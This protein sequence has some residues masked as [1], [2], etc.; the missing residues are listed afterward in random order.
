MAN[1]TSMSKSDLQCH[2]C[3]KILKEPVN[4]PCHCTICHG[5]LTDGSVK[6]GI[7]KCESCNEMFAVKDIELVVNKYAKLILDAEVHLSPE[8]K[9]MKREIEKLCNEFQLLYD[10]LQH[11]QAAF[12]VSSYNHFAEIKHQI[13][14]QREELKD[15]IDK[16]SLAMI[17]RVEQYEA[18]YKLKL[19]ENRCFKEFNGETNYFEDE[20]RKVDLTI[21]R[22]HQLQAK[23]EANVKALQDKMT[24]LK[25]VNEQMKKCSFEAKKDFDI[26][27]FG[28]LYLR[29][30][31]RY[32][33]S[34]SADKTIKLWDLETNQCIRTLEGHRAQI[35]CMDVLSNG[36]LISCSND[37]SFKLWNPSDGTCL[38]TISGTNSTR[39][40]VLSGNRVAC[41]SL[42]KIHIW[43]LNEEKCITTLDGHDNWI[44]C[45]LALP[46]ETLASCS[47]DKTIKLWNL[48]EST[49]IQT[50]YGHSDCVNSLLLLKDG[51]LASGSR[52]RT[53][54]IWKRD[55]GEC[56]KTLVGHTDCIWALDLTDKI[57]LI[58]CSG[59][60]S[61]K[62]WNVASGQCIRTLLR[63]AADVNRI[64]VYSND[65]LASGSWDNSIQLW[66][67]ANGKCISTLK[68]HTALISSFI[69]I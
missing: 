46:D 6:D 3:S 19:D 38:K 37:S 23:Y 16:I 32:L 35:Q 68:G 15:K 56:I 4:L 63:H 13:D 41:G 25:L 47:Q 1:L 51:L 58:S 59:D 11:E 39:L 27:S 61:I 18:F 28:S 22:A 48:N 26:S 62:I 64:I 54:K 30:L 43:D 60:K 45:I 40:K 24:N 5:H 52:D 57:D 69:F 34:S 42:K 31:K 33:A 66:D 65:S 17:T 36:Q 20:F 55:S 9:A 12:E 50:F 44:Q 49:C 2:L 10:Q 7:I 8:E 67:L 14:L 29:N 53:I 21:E